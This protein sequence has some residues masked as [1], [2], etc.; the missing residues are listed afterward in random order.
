MLT[1]DAADVEAI[2]PGL[3][4]RWRGRLFVTRSQAEYI[5]F[6]DAGVSKS[7]AL[8]WLC[9]SQGLRQERSV[10]C[11]DGLTDVG[12]PEAVGIADAAGEVTGDAGPDGAD[13]APDVADTPA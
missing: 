7:R 13:A 8:D 9:R 11:G 10:A 2:L 12:L 3:Q 4:R 5:E 6:V 1:T